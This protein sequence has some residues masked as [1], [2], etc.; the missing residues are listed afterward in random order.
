[1][2]VLERDS[3]LETVWRV[4]R[5]NRSARFPRRYLPDIRDIDINVR[6][7]TNKWHHFSTPPL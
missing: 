7:D 6:A 1:M 4:L 3:T 5:Q 2:I